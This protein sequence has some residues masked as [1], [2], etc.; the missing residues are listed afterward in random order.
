MWKKGTTK[1]LISSLHS[2]GE[3]EGRADVAY[4]RVV[5][6]R[7]GAAFKREHHKKYETCEE[8]CETTDGDTSCMTY[9]PFERR[10]KDQ[11][12]CLR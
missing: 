9:V 1:G 5:D 11:P 3:E 10:Y 2:V 6:T 7:T 8:V 12:P 4:N